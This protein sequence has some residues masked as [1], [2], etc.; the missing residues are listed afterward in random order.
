[1]SIVS[2]QYLGRY[3]VSGHAPAGG[4]HL[5]HV[6][7]GEKLAHIISTNGIRS[8]EYVLQV[9]WNRPGDDEATVER[10]RDVILQVSI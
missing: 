8:P 9:G 1:M 3:V 2:V 5:G 10:R 7:R 4:P 6:I